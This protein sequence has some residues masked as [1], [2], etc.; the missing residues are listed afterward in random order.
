MRV[1]LKW[2]ILVVA[3]LFVAFQ[4]SRANP[5]NDPALAIKSFDP[6]SSQA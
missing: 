2:S 5:P 3:T 4:A 1:W 6:V